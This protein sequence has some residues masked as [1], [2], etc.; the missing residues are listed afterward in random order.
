MSDT[1]TLPSGIG[2]VIGGLVLCVIVLCV[3]IALLQR[4]LA[5]SKKGSLQR[6]LA[7]PLAITPPPQPIRIATGHG[8][9]SKW[10]LSSIDAYLIDLDGTIYSPSGPI[11]GAAEVRLPFCGNNHQT[12]M[13]TLW[14]DLSPLPVLRKRAAT[15]ASRFFVEHWCQ[16]R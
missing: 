10:P 2:S 13:L 7:C 11:E 6:P 1:M 3:R 15:Q 9:G 4:Q 16:R 5:A 8:A 14:F 12:S